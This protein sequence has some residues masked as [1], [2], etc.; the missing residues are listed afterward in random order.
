MPASP[1]QNDTQPMGSEMQTLRQAMCEFLEGWREDIA[2]SWRAHLAD[3]EPAFG[4]I[5]PG[6]TL[7]PSEVIYPGRKGKEPEGAQPGSHI[8]K[9]LDGMAPKDVRVVI[10]GQD[11][12]PN[13]AQATGRAFDQG[14][15]HTWLQDTPPRSPTT[16]LRRIIQQLASF[17][18]G[19]AA[20]SAA[21][22]GWGKVKEDMQRQAVELEA[23]RA[24]FDKWQSQGVLLLNAGLTIT[25]FQ[26][27][28]QHQGHI[29]LWRPVVGAICSRLAQQ[30][31]TPVIFVCWGGDALKF[32]AKIGVITSPQKPVRLSADKQNVAVL[33]RPHPSISA[34]LEG[35]NLFSEL[36]AA[37]SSRGA[38]PIKW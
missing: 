36:N 3:V 20:Y 31:E 30:S 32:L 24:L 4:D 26:D 27:P 6:L 34:F 8:F 9:A 37:L 18:T 1:L 13:V 33:A 14:D 12:Y 5:N 22:G 11:P 17:R 25:R 10:I 21:A 35:E 2:P 28:H 29:P 7:N 16:S 23:P 15:R 19:N 38:A